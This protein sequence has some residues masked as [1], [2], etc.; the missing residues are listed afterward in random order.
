MSAFILEAVK[1]KLFQLSTTNT[2]RLGGL[3]HVEEHIY[4]VG[5]LYSF[6]ARQN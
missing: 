4:G 2:K 1:L 6:L 5:N 3:V